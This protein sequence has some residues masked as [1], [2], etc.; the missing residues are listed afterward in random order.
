[1]WV[2]LTRT[3][4]IYYRLPLV[5][6]SLSFD[7]ESFVKFH[8]PWEPPIATSNCPLTTVP[9]I[10]PPAPDWLW[11]SYKPFPLHFI[12]VYPWS[13]MST[14]LSHQCLEAFVKH[15]HTLGRMMKLASKSK[16]CFIFFYFCV[17]GYGSGKVRDMLLWVI[18]KINISLLLLFL[19]DHLFL[20]WRWSYGGSVRGNIWGMLNHH[21]RLSG[22]VGLQ[23]VL[24]RDVDICTNGLCT[25]LSQQP[26]SNLPLA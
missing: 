2:P 16:F 24:F 18:N 20:K 10:Q 21:F 9:G 17:S 4:L 6:L 14:W 7:L 3:K 22:Y 8:E 19:R 1:M 12:D 5:K 26:K 25:L 15:L 11:E 23:Y 13:V